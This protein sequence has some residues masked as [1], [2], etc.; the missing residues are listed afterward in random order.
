MR[1][2]SIAIKNLFLFGTK[3]T[4]HQK[5]DNDIPTIILNLLKRDKVRPAVNSVAKRTLTMR[6]V[7]DSIPSPTTRHRCDVSSELRYPG[8]KPRRWAPQLVTRF[9]VI[10]RV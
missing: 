2:N 5:Q 4:Y 10:R 9:D 6:E 1:S 7:W 3:K 8:A